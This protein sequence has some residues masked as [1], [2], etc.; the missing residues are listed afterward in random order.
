M[1]HNELELQLGWCKN[2]SFQYF[3][4]ETGTGVSRKQNQCGSKGR[5]LWGWGMD[6]VQWRTL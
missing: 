1:G 5:K 3:G 2:K 6:R 4:G